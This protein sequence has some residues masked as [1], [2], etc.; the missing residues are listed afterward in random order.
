MSL[1]FFLTKLHCFGRGLDL[2]KHFPDT[3]PRQKRGLK[4]RLYTTNTVTMAK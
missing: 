3:N 1:N 2:L 4:R